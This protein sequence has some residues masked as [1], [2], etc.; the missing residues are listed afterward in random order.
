MLVRLL[1]IG[2]I[3]ITYRKMHKE[4]NKFNSWCIQKFGN[5]F[6]SDWVISP[7]GVVQRR[8]GNLTKRS[9]SKKIG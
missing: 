4:E 6:K 1:T 2:N 9:G 3:H 8:L 7:R 5:W